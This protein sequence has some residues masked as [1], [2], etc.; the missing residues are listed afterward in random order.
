MTIYPGHKIRCGTVRVPEDRHQE[1]GK[2]VVL[3][4]A[5]I[6]PPHEVAAQPPLFVLTGGPGEEI[7][8]YLQYTLEPFRRIIAE[9]PVIFYD[10]RG[11][12]LSQPALACPE[13]VEAN[14]KALLR[15][16][17]PDEEFRISLDAYADCKARLEESGV[18]LSSFNSAASADDVR[19]IVTALGYPKVYLYGVSYGTFLG[20]VTLLR[21]QSEG[22]I[23]GAILDSVIPL[24]VD[25]NKEN[26][27]N[28]QAIFKYIF[29]HCAEDPKC[30]ARYPELEKT[31]YATLDQLQRSPLEVITIDPQSAKG[32]VIKMD[33]EDFVGVLFHMLYDPEQASSIPQIIDRASRGDTKL[34]GHPYRELLQ[35]YGAGYIGMTMSVW[36]ADEAST[37]NLDAVHQANAALDPAF[38]KLAEGSAEELQKRCRLWDVK[39]AE[40]KQHRA[41]KTKLPILILSGEQD[42]ITPLAWGEL[43]HSSIPG[44]YFYSFPGTGHAVFF[45]QPDAHVCAE[46]LIIQF[47]GNSTQP[48]DGS[49]LS[50]VKPL[51]FQ[52]PSQ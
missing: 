21:H 27:T 35:E 28:K 31:F 15:D 36:C 19:D 22:W 11:I 49:C 48:P 18:S 13:V 51:P 45:T 39:P 8:N 9:R 42:P 26:W 6:E 52:V 32:M 12:G 14:Q 23:S 47:M 20:Q 44:S 5:V 46:S 37:I 1:N 29:S 41:L 25:F 4:V 7:L 43:L 50:R 34:L 17:S 16:L 2:Q 3:S 10:Q 24:Q 33:D 30:N 38:Q 40:I